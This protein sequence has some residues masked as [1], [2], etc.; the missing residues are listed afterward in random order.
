MCNLDADFPQI[1]DEL[2]AKAGKAKEG[3]RSR[4]RSRSRL[5]FFQLTNYTGIPVEEILLNPGVGGE[6]EAE[7]GV[8]VGVGDEEK[9]E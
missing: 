3:S 8:G 7:V 4:S 5:V 1:K 2:N 9:A 6:A